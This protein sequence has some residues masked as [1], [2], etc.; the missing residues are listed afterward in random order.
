MPSRTYLR[1]PALALLAAAACLG[2]VGAVPSSA[3]LVAAEPIGAVTTVTATTSGTADVVLYDD[4]T[5]SP[6]ETHNPDVSIAGPGRVVGFTLTRTDEGGD[7]LMAV[8]MPSFAGGLVYVDGSTTP[9][10]PRCTQTADPL[11]S[12]TC[13]AEPK[14]KAI[15]LHEGYYHLAVLTDGKPLRITLHL[16]GLARTRSS[17]HLQAKVRTAEVDLP[18]RESVGSTT[19]TYGAETANAGAKHVTMLVRATL[20]QNATLLAQSECSRHDSG[21]PPPYAFSPACPGGSSDGVAW[22]SNNSVR[23]E[24]G[25]IGGL[26]VYDLLNAPLDPTGIGGAFVDTDG[27][28]YVG[29]IGIWSWSDDIDFFGAQLWQMAG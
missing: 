26:S 19:I 18:A 9:T 6:R 25:A 14:P 2:V 7:L 5:L 12:N 16:H 1:R 3:H 29:G 8:R 15:L 27:P 10:P 23:Q 24:F 28:A 17:V 13:P 4:A 11:Q 20:H 21:T 22:E